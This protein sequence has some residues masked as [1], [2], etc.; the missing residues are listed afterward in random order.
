VWDREASAHRRMMHSQ[1]R[2][3]LEEPIAMLPKPE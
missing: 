3:D 1:M 2:G